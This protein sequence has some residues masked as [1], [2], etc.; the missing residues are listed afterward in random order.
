M[1]E[2]EYLDSSKAHRWRS[3]V[4]A[5]REGCSVD[6]VA[7]H[8]ENCFYKTLRQIQKELPFADMIRA[9]DSPEELA[10]VF[11]T[12]AGGTDVKEFLMQAALAKASRSEQLERFLGS[13]LNNCL[14][15]IPYMATD[16]DGSSRA[17]SSATTPTARAST[18][19]VR[20]PKRRSTQRTGGRS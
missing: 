19:P 7:D 13:A 1:A 16:C 11:Q 10:R 9:L 18:K 14:N 12:V 4:Q 3:V 20:N 17:R 15:D 2:N 5:I 6:E 8:V